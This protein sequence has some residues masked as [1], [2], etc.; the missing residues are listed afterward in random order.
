[1]GISVQQGSPKPGSGG[2]PNPS[3]TCIKQPTFAVG[4]RQVRFDAGGDDFC[5]HCSDSREQLRYLV[6]ELQRGKFQPSLFGELDFH[7]ALVEDKPRR[8]AAADAEN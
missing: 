5:G 2:S 7:A 3:F 4:G 6:I 8:E 1:M